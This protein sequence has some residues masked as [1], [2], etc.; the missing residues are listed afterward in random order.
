VPNIVALKD[1]AGDPAETAR[2]MRDAPD[3]FELYSGD[4]GL[5]LP[6]LALG[7]VG[8]VSVCSHWAGPEMAAMVGAFLAGDTAEARRCNARLLDSYAFESSDDAPNPIPTKVALGLLGQPAGECRLP[9]G[10]PPA[11]LADRAR[12]VLAGLGRQV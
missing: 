7:A 1:A 2:V 6:L 8:V 3:D 4:D 10:P 11:G 9:L 12:Q 5:T